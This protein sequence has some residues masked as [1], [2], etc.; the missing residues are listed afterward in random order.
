LTHHL[1][2]ILAT[3]NGAIKTRAN[4][5]I[6]RQILIYGY[7]RVSTSEQE[8][9]LQLDALQRVGVKYIFQEKRSGVASRP[10]LMSLL[11]RLGTGDKIYVYK[12]DRFA[13]SLID[14]LA[15][16][17][18]IETAGATFQSLTEPIDTSTG[19]GRMMMHMLGAFA[20]FERGI[21]RERCMAGQ[22]AAM[23]RGVHCGRPRSLK[24]EQEIDI[25][26]LYGQGWYTLDQL[27]LIFDCHP[28]TV[29]RAVYRVLKPGHS[30]LK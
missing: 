15:I 9:T 2:R 17:Q 24:R 11:A 22:Q 27:A 20:E 3:K 23:S 28:S 16:L 19:A 30:S 13:R 5:Q 4:G 10:V 6:E 14:L 25:V 1:F 7:A 18:K 29:K 21:I 8:T 12:I 26:R